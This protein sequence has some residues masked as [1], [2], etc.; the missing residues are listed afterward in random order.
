MLRLAATTLPFLI[1]CATAQQALSTTFGPSPGGLTGGMVAVGA[2]FDGD[3]AP[4]ATY[5]LT[6]GGG[7]ALI[8]IGDQNGDGITELARLQAGGTE[9]LRLANPPVLV[10]IPFGGV[11][12]A[13][14]NM[15]GDSRNEVLVGEANNQM[16]RSFSPATGGTLRTWNQA[17]ALQAFYAPT[18]SAIGVDLTNGLWARIG[19]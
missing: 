5:P 3:G 2:D 1:A 18:Q 12:I 9:I 15:A 10:A 7:N 14:A 13:A 8:A 17:I 16:V 6:F 4:F 11:A 19:W